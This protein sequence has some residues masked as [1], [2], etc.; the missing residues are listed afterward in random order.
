MSRK[1]SKL[2]KE[3]IAYRANYRCEYCLL[4]EKLSLYKFHI[5]HIKSVKHGGTDEEDNLAYCCPDCNYFKGSDIA[6]FSVSDERLVRLFRSLTIF[7]VRIFN[8]TLNP[9]P[10]RRGTM[11][12]PLLL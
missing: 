8:L 3:K 12:C 5:E 7:V 2:L 1:F 9:S 6:T 10:V 4:P 11:Y